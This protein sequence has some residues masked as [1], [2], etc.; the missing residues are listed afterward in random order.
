[1]VVRTQL[2]PR[3]TCV[4]DSGAA[5]Q[6]VHLSRS[7]A[8]QSR[9]PV[10]QYPIISIPLDQAS[11]AFHPSEEQRTRIVLISW[12]CRSR[13]GDRNH[14]SNLRDW[15]PRSNVGAG[16]CYQRSE[17]NIVAGPDHW[18]WT[19]KSLEDCATQEADLLVASDT[20]EDRDILRMR[21]RP[22]GYK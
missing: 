9:D 19:I 21:Q 12:H 18:V 11:T 2:T 13:S 6:R 3:D 1:M 8:W 20:L 5:L 22:R 17:L 10:W 16:A 14:R 4:R 7:G 15:R